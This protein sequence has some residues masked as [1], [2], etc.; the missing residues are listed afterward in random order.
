MIF[1]I[2]F[3]CTPDHV[4]TV[5]DEFDLSDEALA[6]LDPAEAHPSRILVYDDIGGFEVIDADDPIS[7]AIEYRA[8]GI[9]AEPDLKRSTGAT[10]TGLAGGDDPFASMQ[11]NFEFIGYDADQA[12]G[13]GATVAVVDTGVST[14]GDDTPLRMETGWDFVMGEPGAED[15]NGHGTHV[16][17]TIAQATNN[18]VGVAGLAP[19]A[20]ILPVRVLDEDGSGWASDVALGIVYAVDEGA[21]VINLSLGS[22]EPSRAERAAIRYARNHEVLVVAAAGNSG[23]RTGFPAAYP[24]AVAVAATGADGRA[25]SYSNV[26]ATELAAPGGDLSAD[27]DGNGFGDGIL[28]ETFVDGEWG[29]WFFQGTSMATP[30][31]A[32]AAALL[33]GQGMSP[34]EAREALADTAADYGKE[35]KDARYGYGIIDL[36]AALGS[37]DESDE[38][39]NP[40]GQ[41]HD[42]ND[43]A[44]DDTG[45]AWE[46]F[47]YE[48]AGERTDSECRV[49]FRVPDGFEVD[50]YVCTEDAC[51]QGLYGTWLDTGWFESHGETYTIYIGLDGEWSSWGPYVF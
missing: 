44:N 29:Y 19:D 2:L 41:G 20:T 40:N 21:D 45:P 12:S 49:Q 27:I 43:D 15:L 32:G 16:A 3:A 26:G 13:A 48:V 11:W 18:G 47:V 39:P 33:I 1:A 46:S 30:H 38:D 4:T 42:G 5:A 25:T 28:Q 6:A 50:A 24:Y 36:E 35:G 51:V 7:A 23:D 34:L 37:M 22:D 8:R 17:G 14:R 10:P 9:Y 31:V